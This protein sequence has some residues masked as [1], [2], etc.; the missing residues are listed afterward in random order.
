MVNLLGLLKARNSFRFFSSI[1]LIVFISISLLGCSVEELKEEN[2]P[3]AS[4]SSIDPIGNEHGQTNVDEDDNNKTEDNK[5]PEGNLSI[6]TEAQPKTEK[7]NNELSITPSS[8]TLTVHY[9]NVG[10]GDATLLQSS[11]FNIL[12]DAG[13]HDKNDIVPYLN[14]VGIKELDVLIG[15]HAHADHIGQ[16]DKVLQAFPVKEVWMSGDASN[17]KTFERVIDAIA[18]SGVSYYEPRTGDVF[19]IGSADILILNP[20]TLTGDLHE[21]SLSLKISYGEISFLFTGD[22]EKQTEDLMIRSDHDLSSHIFQ[23]GHHG[24][25]TSNTKA[26]LEIVKPEVAIYSAGA[27][28]SYGHPHDEVIQRLKDMKITVYG[29][30]HHGTV[31]VITDGRSYEVKTEK[32][33]DITSPVAE[34]KQEEP[35]K[36]EPANQVPTPSPTP[37]AGTCGPGQVNIN[38]ASI[39]E[40]KR[41]KHIDDVRGEE[42]I[43]LRP[44]RSIDDLAR[45]KG[46]AAAR[47]KDI[48]TEGIAC[49]D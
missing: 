30:D 9:I 32:S 45:I 47:I 16:M 48:K 38:K 10:Q 17:S 34:P 3:I 1:L 2:L 26:F 15:T 11:D 28:N 39:E 13:R 49:V 4:E 31:Q 44:F 25:S 6:K 7:I 46:I 29:T 35:K 37:N 24:S 5:Q 41:I 36:E 14:S 22:A 8:G 27:G 43:K 18:E 20:K 19:E 40:V 21:G 42:L 23:L 12:I 33:G